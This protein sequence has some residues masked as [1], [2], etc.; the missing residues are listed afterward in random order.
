MSMIPRRLQARQIREDAAELASLREHPSHINNG[1]EFKYRRTVGETENEKNQPSHLANFTKGLPHDTETGLLLNPTDYRQFVL[2]IQSGSTTDFNLTPLGPAKTVSGRDPD[3]LS[4]E[5]ITSNTSPNERSKIWK[6]LIAQTAENSADERKNPSFISEA[7][8]KGA[9]VRAWESAGAGLAFELEGFDSQAVTMP[10]APTLNS[11][12]LA[13]EITEVYLQALLRDIPFSQLRQ[14]DSGNTI[15]LRVQWAVD[16]LNNVSIEQKN[17]FNSDTVDL[18]ELGDENARISHPERFFRSLSLTPTEA[19]R[20]RPRVTPQNLFRGIAPRDHIGPY[21]S[22]FLLIGNEGVNG[23]DKALKPFDGYVAYGSVRVD[24]RVRMATPCKDYMTTF[25]QWVDVQNG[26]DLRGLESYEGSKYRFMTTPRDLATYVHYDALYEAYLN[27]CL[28]LLNMGAPFD[29]GIPFQR[30]DTEDKQQG[31]ATFGGPVILTLVCE[32]ATRALKAVRFQKFNTHRRLRPEALAGL[33][34]RYLTLPSLLTKDMD[35]QKR[36]KIKRAIEEL[37]PV[38]K[39]VTALEGVDLLE[40]VKEHNK[41]QNGASSPD[42][43]FLPMAFPEGS[44]MHPSYGAGHATVAGACVTILKAFFDH[45]W[46]ISKKDKNTGKYIAYEPKDDGSGL[47]TLLLDQP[48][49]VEG[50]LNK[51]AANIA[52]GRDWAGV[53]Y[54]TDYI[55]SL[56]LGEQIAIGI[57]QEQKLTFGENFSMTV[58]LFDGGA[59]QI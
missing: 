32:V 18:W 23:K 24:Q 36:Q 2:G 34:D 12:E 1:E 7:Q 37:Q 40:A 14:P 56:R 45:G 41:G 13:A 39:L 42:S 48:L 8:R 33:I 38:A 17:W 25:E 59:I 4:V 6:S 52:I 44:P 50:E 49:T 31:F 35:E 11:V 55:E 15:D 26:A 54:F 30:P 21:L 20:K 29:P 57:L 43:Y 10:P 53:H 47:N 51:V 19:K 16:T 5:A 3:A 28:I 27:A 58:P 46:Q 22:Q 9:K